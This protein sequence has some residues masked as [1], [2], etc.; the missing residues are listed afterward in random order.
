[1]TDTAETHPVHAKP[2]P[3]VDDPLTAPF[4]AATRESRLVL[5]RCTNCSYLQWPPEPVCPECQHTGR[6]WRE[7]PARGRL[8]SFAV[9]HRAL[10]PA[11]AADV[12][13]AVGLVE[14]DAGRKMYGLMEGDAEALR[15]GARV[16]GVFDAV[17]E[18]VTFI[19]WRIDD[20]D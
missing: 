9:Y 5:P 2:L 19:R 18:D 13:Y 7:F 8:W 12:P 10:D 4:W 16:R 20:R 17:N 15:V 1:M 6:E 3:D 11:F 14:L